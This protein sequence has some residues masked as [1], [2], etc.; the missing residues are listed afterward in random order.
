MVQMGGLAMLEYALILL[1]LI[2]ILTIVLF[3]V[4]LV[5]SAGFREVVAG[6]K[7]EGRFSLL[8]VFSVEGVGAI[9][10][11]GLLMGGGVIFPLYQFPEACFRSMDERAKEHDKARK[12]LSDLRDEHREIYDKLTRYENPQHW[13]I[14]G[15]LSIP[16]ESNI[17]F[18]DYQQAR[19]FWLQGRWIGFSRNFE[20]VRY[21]PYDVQISPLPD[22]SYRVARFEIKLI[23]PGGVDLP[24]EI[25][26]IRYEHWGA[27][28]FQGRLFDDL[29]GT[30]WSK[31]GSANIEFRRPIVLHRFDQLTG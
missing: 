30:P 12:E 23:I 1:P 17:S 13:S 25:A 2:A 22:M 18:S 31:L 4:A 9:L 28:H 14:T 27:T 8:N 15:Y 16:G 5:F 19:L 10:V 21:A 20:R 26:Q 24:D 3:G 7:Q 29:F 11:L 6:L